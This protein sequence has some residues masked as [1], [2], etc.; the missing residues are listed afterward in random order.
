MYFAQVPP[1]L[2]LAHHGL[3]RQDW[4]WP[5]E[6]QPVLLHVPLRQ[7]PAARA[8][9]VLRAQPHLQDHPLLHPRSPVLQ[10][11]LLLLRGRAH[12]PHLPLRR[13]PRPGRPRLCDSLGSCLYANIY[14]PSSP[15]PPHHQV[16][17]VTD[18]SEKLIYLT[19]TLLTGLKAAKML[20]KLL[21]IKNMTSRTSP[22]REGLRSS[23]WQRKKPKMNETVEWIWKLI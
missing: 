13:P 5:L 16:S 19:H 14:C 1:H 8:H 18:V 10:R 6:V 17:Q 2:G 7:P 12:H 15:L 4:G 11:N 3:H 20:S 23:C 21:I 22:R 9:P